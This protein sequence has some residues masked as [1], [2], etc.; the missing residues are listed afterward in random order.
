MKVKSLRTRI[1]LW[2]VT[3]MLVLPITVGAVI[4]LKQFTLAS[5]FQKTIQETDDLFKET[6]LKDL[7]AA[8]M[9]NQ[10]NG[11]RSLLARLAEFKG[12]QGVYLTDAK[13][14][15]VLGY[16]TKDAPKLTA[17]QWDQVL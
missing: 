15:D 7:E 2:T 8:M 3:A 13:G 17:R 11:M 6:L 12:V 9:A 14:T 4:I 5:H 10:L 1:T 16:G